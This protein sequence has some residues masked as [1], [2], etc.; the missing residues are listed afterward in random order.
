MRSQL[1]LRLNKLTS[2]KIYSFDA[3]ERLYP[4]NEVIVRLSHESNTHILAKDCVREVLDAL[5]G[6]L[7]SALKNDAQLHESIKQ[8]IGY[9]WNEELQRKP[10]LTYATL[11]SG[12]T[13]W[14]GLD[15]LLW[16]TPGNAKLVLSTWLYNTLDTAIMLEITPDYPWHFRQSK[17][18]KHFVTYEEWLQRYKSLAKFIIPSN[19][20]LAWKDKIEPILEALEN[21]AAKHRRV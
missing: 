3:L 13:Y 10:G 6:L 1:V 11:D 17:R 8:D 21:N 2:I 5:Y 18:N 15:N 14:V 20:A 9:L 16:E 19:I 12:T 7:T 4:C